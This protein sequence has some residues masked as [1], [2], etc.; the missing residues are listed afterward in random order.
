[1]RI[2]HTQQ[3]PHYG[4][5]TNHAIPTHVMMNLKFWDIAVA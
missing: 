1:M 4:R 2:L 3:D 5:L